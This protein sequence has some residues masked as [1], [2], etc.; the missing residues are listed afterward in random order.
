MAVSRTVAGRRWLIPLTA[1]FGWAA[2]TG[3]FSLSFFSALDSSRAE[4]VTANDFLLTLDDMLSA[5]QDAETGQRGYLITQNLAYLEP[6]HK[7]IAAGEATLN[8]LAGMHTSRPEQLALT[9]KMVAEN[10]ADDARRSLTGDRGKLIMDQLR[11]VVGDLRTAEVEARHTVVGEQKAGVWRLLFFTQTTTL[12]G[13]CALLYLLY[14][15]QSAQ[16]ALRV[17][18]ANRQSAEELAAERSKQSGVC[19]S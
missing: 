15:S 13:L 3:I 11:A 9:V 16:Q 12:L 10:R 6:Y 14:R 5:A 18:V 2:L 17:E 4:L 7:G 19:V 1:I 8:R